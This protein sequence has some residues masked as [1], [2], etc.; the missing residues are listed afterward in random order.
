M[1]L[2]VEVF[3][4]RSGVPRLV[5]FRALKNSARISSFA[6]SLMLKLRTTPRSMVSIPGPYTELRLALPN[7]YAAGVL[8][9]AGLNHVAALCVPEGKTDAPVTLARI[10]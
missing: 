2:K 7:V 4:N 9:A 10:G 8:N 5:W 3:T 1:L 6:S